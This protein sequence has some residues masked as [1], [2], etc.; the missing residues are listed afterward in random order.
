MKRKNQMPSYY[1]KNIAQNAQRKFF[2]RKA[3]EA[4]KKGKG[5]GAAADSVK[6]A[7]LK[8]AARTGKA[9]ARNAAEAG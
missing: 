8:P 5:P 1:G 9:G 4:E 2:K 6:K 7:E 3:L